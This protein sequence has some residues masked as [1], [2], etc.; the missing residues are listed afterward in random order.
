MDFDWRHRRPGRNEFLNGGMSYNTMPCIYPFDGFYGQAGLIW[1][2]HETETWESY[3]RLSRWIYQLWKWTS[4]IIW[5]QRS[6]SS[7]VWM[8]ELGPKEDWGSK[9]W[10]FG[11]VVLEK[12][13]ESPLD[14]KE[15]KPV[16]PKGNQSWICIGRTD[17]EAEVPILWPPD[18]KS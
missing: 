1:R 2:R 15:I 5:V 4:S 13:L 8:W 11:T 12:I 9:N 16:N 17:A 7:H 14:Y 3:R 10:C 6:S 18:V